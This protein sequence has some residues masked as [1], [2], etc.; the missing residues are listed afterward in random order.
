M[1]R[2]SGRLEG[3]RETSKALNDM[4]KAMA[5]GVGRKALK[6]PAEMLARDVRASA[7]VLSGA[8]RESV[9][10]FPSPSRRGAPRIEVRA[11]DIAS[12]QEEFGNSDQVANP[13]FRRAIDQ[14]QQRRFEAFGDALMIETND[15]VIR[16]AKKSAAKG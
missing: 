3:F 14:G 8:L 4:S 5:R 1:T 6:I 13:F 9:D 12:V 15:A 7:T 11:E 10:V 16:A 2:R